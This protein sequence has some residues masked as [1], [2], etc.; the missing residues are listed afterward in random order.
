MPGRR[1]AVQA[2]VC[3][4]L[5]TLV[6]IF[7]GLMLVFAVARQFAIRSTVAFVRGPGTY[8]VKAVG[9]TGHQAPMALLTRTKSRS[10]KRKLPATLVL[11][12]H[13]PFDSQ[14]VR[15]DIEGLTVGFL[16]RADAQALRANAPR[17]VL[18]K[19][20]INCNAI[21]ARVTGSGDGAQTYYVRLDLP[22]V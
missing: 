7:I 9:E 1:F 4:A 18:Q 6:F 22:V 5:M 8:R 21:I 14:A 15:V 20:C 16:A 12:D 19:G 10:G 17:L 3:T 2:P 13:N 11:D